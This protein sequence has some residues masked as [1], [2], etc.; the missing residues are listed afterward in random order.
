MFY[1]FAG[2][3][4]TDKTKAQTQRDEFASQLG[5]QGFPRVKAEDWNELFWLLADKVKRGRVIV[6]LDE[7]SWMGSQ[8]PHFL[9]KLKMH[10]I[11]I[12]KKILILF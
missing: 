3:A 4:P 7:I 2:V 6:L 11:S 8:D 1:S 5:H 12:S 9:G 10:G